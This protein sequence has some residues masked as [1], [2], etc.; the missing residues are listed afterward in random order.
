MISW[1]RLVFP[2]LNAWNVFQFYHSG[3]NRKIR[4]AK[5]ATIFG[6]FVFS[7]SFNEILNALVNLESWA[8]K[9]KYWQVKQISISWIVL[10]LD[11]SKNKVK[12]DHIVFDL[13]DI[14]QKRIHCYSNVPIE[15]EISFFINKKNKQWFLWFLFLCHWRFNHPIISS[16]YA[17]HMMNHLCHILFNIPGFICIFCMFFKC[18]YCHWWNIKYITIFMPVN[19]QGPQ[20]QT[21]LKKRFTLDYNKCCMSFFF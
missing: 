4:S 20:T 18:C 12:H 19:R 1:F 3:I 21:P 7:F 2:S 5:F 13:F 10:P 15:E 14:Q 9:I 6:F 17:G 11:N 8:I 16:L